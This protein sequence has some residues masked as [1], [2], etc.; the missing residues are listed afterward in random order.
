MVHEE[1]RIA[2]RG[3]GVGH[4]GAGA[5]VAVRVGAALDAGSQVVVG[6]AGSARVDVRL[7]DVRRSRLVLTAR[8][9]VVGVAVTRSDV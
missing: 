4:D 9:A 8:Q 2:R 1:E 5:V 3:D 7:I 6:A